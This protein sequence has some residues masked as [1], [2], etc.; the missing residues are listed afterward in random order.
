MDAMNLRLYKAP[1]FDP[2]YPDIRRFLFEGK[3]L[4][5]QEARPLDFYLYVWLNMDGY[6]HAFQAVMEDTITVA[7]Q[8][9]DRLRYGKVSRDILNRGAT[10]RESSEER[11]RLIAVIE[12]MT[13]REFPSLFGSIRE[14]VKGEQIPQIKLSKKEKKIFITLCSKNGCM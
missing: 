12:N 1:F 4:S 14:I 8:M 3:A 11:K 7:Y 6:L 10:Q 9:P 2:I 13:S 5:E